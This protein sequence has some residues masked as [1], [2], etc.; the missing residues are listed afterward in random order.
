[1]IARAIF[2]LICSL[3]CWSQEGAFRSNGSLEPLQQALKLADAYNWSDAGPYFDEAEKAAVACAAGGLL[4]VL[5]FAVW[6][7]VFGPRHVG[8]I[9]GAAQMLTVLASAAGPLCVAW[10]RDEFGSYLH[11]FVFL[12]AVSALFGFAALRVSLPLAIRGD[13]ARREH[14]RPVPCLQE[15]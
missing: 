5:F 9:Q 15:T 6:G 11:V 3:L 4:T 1:M 2:L 7:E 12:S 14:K 13:W 10:A 8:R